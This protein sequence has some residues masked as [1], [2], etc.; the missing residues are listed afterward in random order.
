MLKTAFAM[1]DE[2]DNRV[3]NMEYINSQEFICDLLRTV[4]YSKDEIDENKRILIPQH[5]S[6]T[7]FISA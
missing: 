7:L 3:R 2:L 4:D 5:Y 6:L 1:I